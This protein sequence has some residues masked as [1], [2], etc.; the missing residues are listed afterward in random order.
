[1]DDIFSGHSLI[2]ECVY[3]SEYLFTEPYYY[4]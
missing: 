1:M 3:V 2:E 4:T